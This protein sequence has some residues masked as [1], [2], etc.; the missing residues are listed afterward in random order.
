MGDDEVNG[1]TKKTMKLTDFPIKRSNL[2]RTVESKSIYSGADIKLEAFDC[3][4]NVLN[5]CGSDFYF[6]ISDAALILKQLTPDVIKK[7]VPIISQQ[8]LSPKKKTSEEKIDL[9]E[10]GVDMEVSNINASQKQNKPKTLIKRPDA[11]RPTRMLSPGSNS[12]SPVSAAVQALISISAPKTEQT[13]TETVSTS[14]KSFVE[15]PFESEIMCNQSCT[16]EGKSNSPIEAANLFMPVS[17]PTDLNISDVAD[18]AF[19]PVPKFTVTSTDNSAVDSS[20]QSLE[21][22]EVLIT[23]KSTHIPSIVCHPTVVNASSTIFPT[24]AQ[25]SCA[26]AALKTLTSGN[27]TLPSMPQTGTCDINVDERKNL[28]LFK[29][30]NNSEESLPN[31]GLLLTS[32]SLGND[33]SS[34]LPYE[35]QQQQEQHQLPQQ[36]QSSQQQ[37]QQQPIAALTINSNIVRQ[38]SLQPTTVTSLMPQVSQ[39]QS[40]IM[41]T[42]AQFNNQLINAVSPQEISIISSTGD[43][44]QF[45]FVENPSISRPST[46]NFR[47]ILPKPSTVETL[48]PDSNFTSVVSV[49]P[50]SALT[51][52]LNVFSQFT[53]IIKLDDKKNIQ[54]SIIPNQIFGKLNNSNVSIDPTSQLITNKQNINQGFLFSPPVDTVLL[55][56]QQLMSSL[57][58]QQ[59]P[60]EE[61]QTANTFNQHQDQPQQKHKRRGRTKKSHQQQPRVQQQPSFEIQQMKEC[62]VSNQ[63]NQNVQK[64]DE[65]V[66]ENSK[67]SVNDARIPTEIIAEQQ[68]ETLLLDRKQLLVKHQ[69]L[70]QKLR[71]DQQLQEKHQERQKQVEFQN[72]HLQEQQDQELQ[73]NR[74]QQDRSTP[75]INSQHTPP[76]EVLAPQSLEEKEKL[77]IPQQELILLQKQQDELLLQFHKHQMEQEQ[78]QRTRQP[79][80]QQSIHENQ[81][82]EHQ[83]HLE[84]YTK[85]LLLQKPQQPEIMH[86]SHEIEPLKLVNQQQYELFRQ[87]AQE[88]EEQAEHEQLQEDYYVKQQGDSHYQLQQQDQQREENTPN[89][90]HSVTPEILPKN[91]SESTNILKPSNTIEPT[92]IIFSES[93]VPVQK[94]ETGRGNLEVASALLSMRSENE[95]DAYEPSVT[96]ILGIIQCNLVK[97]GQGHIAIALNSDGTLR[98]DDTDIDPKKHKISKGE[99]VLLS[100]FSYTNALT[101]SFWLHFKYKP[102]NCIIYSAQNFKYHFKC[103]LIFCIPVVLFATIENL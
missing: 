25:S 35:S 14:R 84:L 20:Q 95:E 34:T 27:T 36:T 44:Q 42:H 69:Q 78:L 68:S 80:E 94:Q 64:S 29:A 59:V 70:Q 19:I 24:V 56:Q 28:E 93:E 12:C 66:F 40:Q 49:L 52:T 5:E 1:V 10:Q 90:S 55:S 46:I 76:P 89:N 31:F 103:H 97:E 30:Q 47:T 62:D 3:F 53:P 17:R 22:D 11:S 13:N 38:P 61:T 82:L 2:K 39:A 65:R 51:S 60:R 18:S 71:Q 32:S 99:S 33:I 85:K 73:E 96:E 9:F 98:I 23:T 15:K 83:H 41:Q 87:Q 72:R 86:Q 6:S 54:Y 67:T 92:L 58:Q 16:R 48:I 21:V 26:N 102:L 50:S 7:I 4:H 88:V 45:A 77:L 74:Q 37:R 57:L 81:V 63:A 100:E 79:P 8:V 75:G 43:Q 91:T 101:F